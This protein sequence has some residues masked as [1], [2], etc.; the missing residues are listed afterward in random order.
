MKG[1]SNQ[2]RYSDVPYSRDKVRQMYEKCQ[3]CGTRKIDIII[4]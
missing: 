3:K 1:I 2:R 4:R